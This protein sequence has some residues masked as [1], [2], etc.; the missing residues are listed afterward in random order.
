MTRTN[1][2][3][4]SPGR[5]ALYTVVIKF[6]MRQ[7]DQY[8]LTFAQ[9]IVRYTTRKLNEDARQI[10]QTLGAK[11]LLCHRSFRSAALLADAAKNSRW[12]KE[13]LTRRLYKDARQMSAPCMLAV[14][15]HASLR[16]SKHRSNHTTRPRPQI[17]GHHNRKGRTPLWKQAQPK[18]RGK[19][20]T[21]MMITTCPPT[22]GIAL[23][24]ILDPVCF[25]RARSYLSS[26]QPLA[27]NVLYFCPHRSSKTNF[28]RLVAPIMYH[29]LAR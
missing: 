7:S 18:T 11:I 20:G 10:V 8:S 21:M 3:E 15:V 25:F 27:C 28:A 29:I 24:L 22:A 19:P 16:N 5:C 1:H 13:N 2:L 6:M 17:H 14:S 23:G 9:L 26:A 4:E 12:K